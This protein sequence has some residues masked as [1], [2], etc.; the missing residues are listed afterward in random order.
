[1]EYEKAFCARSSK[2]YYQGECKGLADASR[3]GAYKGP[4]FCQLE[5][6]LWRDYEVDGRPCAEPDCSLCSVL[7]ALALRG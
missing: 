2:G 1:M 4:T 3:D 5:F 7:E 6:E